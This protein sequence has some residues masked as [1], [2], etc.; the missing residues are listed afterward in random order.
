M[1]A[2][3]RHGLSLTQA[4]IR[5]AREREDGREKRKQ[6]NIRGAFQ[7]GHNQRG[8]VDGLQ[9]CVSVGAPAQRLS[10]DLIPARI[11]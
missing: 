1:A 5:Q 8:V 11:V 10:N 7:Y 4:E 6:G 3:R 9:Q 2:V